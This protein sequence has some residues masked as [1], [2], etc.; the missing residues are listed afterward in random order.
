MFDYPVRL[1][2]DLLSRALRVLIAVFPTDRL[3]G[4]ANEV[5][6]SAIFYTEESTCL[7]A[8]TFAKKNKTPSH[9]GLI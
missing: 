6:P 5:F 4:G 9:P 3:T 7:V 1:L 2:Q 8:W